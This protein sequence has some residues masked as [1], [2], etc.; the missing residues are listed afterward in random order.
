MITILILIIIIIII[1]IIAMINLHSSFKFFRLT[2]TSSRNSKSKANTNHWARLANSVPPTYYP[3]F[4]AAPPS[5]SSPSRLTAPITCTSISIFQS[6]SFTT[7]SLQMFA[8]SHPYGSSSNAPLV[9]FFKSFPCT[10][11]S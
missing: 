3:T 6:L 11:Y 8:R 1:I 5:H 7:Y 9:G 10:H 2:F 4:S